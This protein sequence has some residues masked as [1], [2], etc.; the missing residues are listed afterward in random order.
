VNQNNYEI[1]SKDISTMFQHWSITRGTR[2]KPAKTILIFIDRKWIARKFL[3]LCFWD[4]K[5]ERLSMYSLV[6]LVHAWRSFKIQTF[7]VQTVGHVCTRMKTLYIGKHILA[8]CDS[9]LGYLYTLVIY[10]SVDIASNRN[11]D[12]SDNIIKSLEFANFTNSMHIWSH[13]HH[14]YFNRWFGDS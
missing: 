10:I 12:Y 13:L 1:Y 4:L 3:W 6:T 9:T 8:R 7:S 5:A 11:C 2:V 14:S